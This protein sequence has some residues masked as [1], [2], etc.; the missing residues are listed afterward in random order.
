MK[1]TGE[2]FGD[3]QKLGGGAGASGG[4]TTPTALDTHTDATAPAAPHRRQPVALLGSW[5]SLA[6]GREGLAYRVE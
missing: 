2:S 5:A 4:T 3:L 1:L 6:R